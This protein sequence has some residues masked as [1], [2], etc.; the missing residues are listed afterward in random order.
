MYESWFTEQ[1]EDFDLLKFFEDFIS[2]VLVHSGKHER[3]STQHL[4]SK[5]EQLL[6]SG[7]LALIQRLFSAYS[8][9]IQR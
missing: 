8:A 2:R 5:F 6:F 9:L 4:S 3:L 7:Y 1:F